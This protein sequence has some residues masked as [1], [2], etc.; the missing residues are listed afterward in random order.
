M[1]M[2]TLPIPLLM[3]LENKKP[4]IP[5][6]WLYE[7]GYIAYTLTYGFRKLKTIHLYTMA[8]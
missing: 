8:I 7:N 5:I 2:H 4:Y 6:P 3:D 1:K